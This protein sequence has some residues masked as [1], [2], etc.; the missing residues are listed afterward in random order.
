MDTPTEASAKSFT[1]LVA[2]EIRVAMARKLMRQSELARVLGVNETWLSVR[3]RGLQPIDLNDL[4]RIA[5][6]L[7]VAVNDLL[8]GIAAEVGPEAEARSQPMRSRP[9]HARARKE[10]NTTGT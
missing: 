6:G 4:A 1:E 7:R 9:T 5:A 10:A 3:L 8:P 2:E